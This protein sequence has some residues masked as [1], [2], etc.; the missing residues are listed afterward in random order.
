[1]TEAPNVQQAIS[2][3]AAA[4]GAVGKHQRMEAGPA[5]YNYRGLDDLI[6]AVHGPLVEAGITFAPHSIQMLDTLE[7]TTRSGSIQYHLRALVTYRVYGP[8][9][10]HIEATVLAE[11]SATGD[12]AGNKLMSGAYKYALGQVLSIP[13]SMDDQDASTPE[14]VINQ[15]K[16]WEEALLRLDALAEA[17]GKSVEQ[18]T[19]KFRKTHGDIGMDG[20]HAL[21]LEQ[22]A[23]LIVQIDQYTKVKR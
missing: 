15:P 6:D 23:P 16:T 22:V 2:A 21:P 17:N 7:K 14:P 13:F 19:A 11:G 3:A 12:K 4:I 18:L 9:G 5:R 20:F 1:M 10:D 8:A